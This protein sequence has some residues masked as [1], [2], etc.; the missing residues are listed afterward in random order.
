MKT[1]LRAFLFFLLFIGAIKYTI[2]QEKIDSLTYYSKLA[3]NPKKKSHFAEAYV[4]F[5]NHKETSLRN[6]DTLRAA[7]CLSYMSTIQ[8]E[9]GSLNDS[10]E[11]AI[12][13][14]KLLD[15]VKKSNYTIGLR[16]TLY[17]QLGKIYRASLDY[18]KALEYYKKG[19]QIV[20]EESQKCVLEN[21]I[22]FVYKEQEEYELASNG[23]KKAYESGI[24]AR[25]T[26]ETARS[27]DNWGFVLSKLNSNEALPK[28][29]QAL[30]LRKEINDN[31]GIHASYKH[32]TE[33]Y[34]EEGNFDLAFEYA[35]K[36]YEVAKLVNSA[37][38]KKDA[39][40]NLVR[41]GDDI[42]AIE[43]IRITDSIGEAQRLAKNDYAE[44]RYNFSEKEKQLQESEI[45]RERQR[46]GK[47]LSQ[48]IGAFLL[49]LLGF[50]LVLERIRHKKKTLKEVYHTESR[51]S[52]K[53]HDEVANSVYHLMTKFQAG[54]ARPKEEILDDLELIYNK[55]R[56]IS[57]DYHTLDEKSDFGEDLRDLLLSYD[58]EQVNIITKGLNDI[59]WEGISSLKRTAIHRTL[60][61][62]LVNMQKHSKAT[63]VFL[64]FS[65]MKSRIELTYM[66]NGIGGILKKQNGLHNVENRI[67]SLNGTVTFDSKPEGGFKVNIEI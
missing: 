32:L 47:I 26:A 66:D 50:I 15:Q 60:Q 52:Q 17:N 54:D 12:E 18:D 24:R 28:M 37:S 67:H 45:K 9:L 33:Y 23:F 38:Y 49:L 65:K 10:Q 61:E 8:N 62:L 36:A 7:Y 43:L 2:S 5:R 39:L 25:D 56:D 20:R 41:L 48:A 6:K 58:S 46:S 30:S 13:A 40:A 27:L 59:R 31:M 42:N 21:N 4:Y 14:I 22:A 34:I 29:K 63:S 44:A 57:R 55:S 11:S 3:D 1:L 51:I 53:V 16:I 35:N 19:L 64:T